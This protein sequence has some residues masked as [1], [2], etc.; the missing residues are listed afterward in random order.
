MSARDDLA[1]QSGRVATRHPGE[2]DGR[3]GVAGTLEHPTGPIAQRQDV[4]RPGEVGRLGVRADE[5]LDRRRPIARRDARRGAVAV[6]DRHGERGALR[7]GVLRDHERQLELV[8]ALGGQRYADQAGGVGEEEGH[9][10]GSRELRRHHEVALVLAVGVVDDD[11]HLAS[12]YGG[13]RLLDPGQRHV[14]PCLLVRS[15]LPAGRGNDHG[16]RSVIAT[17]SRAQRSTVGLNVDPQVGTE[18][19]HRDEPAAPRLGHRRHARP[20]EDR[21]TVV[22]AEKRRRE[23][24][25]RTGR[26]GRLGGTR[27]RRARHLRR[28]AAGPLADRARRARRRGRRRALAPDVREHRRG[29]GRARREAAVGALDGSPRRVVAHR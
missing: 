22:A 17:R 3:L 25:R 29:R 7:L 20:G 23:V 1:E 12:T 4:T 14:D 11:D 28:G 21:S 6:V 10:L 27:G 19:A 2:I 16:T 5:R 24:R 9:L 18:L 15:S 13:D 26:R 8:E